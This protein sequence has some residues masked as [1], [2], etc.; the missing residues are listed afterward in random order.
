MEPS[1]A[2]LPLSTKTRLITII[3][4]KVYLS[5]THGI[6]SQPT[7]Q[8]TFKPNIGNN[9]RHAAQPYQQVCRGIYLWYFH[10]FSFYIENR[11]LN[12]QSLLQPTNQ[13]NKQDLPIIVTIHIEELTMESV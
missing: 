5:D 2:F 9:Y 10:T 6:Q 8:P 11:T 3:G 12:I 4:D 1:S 13:T 7:S